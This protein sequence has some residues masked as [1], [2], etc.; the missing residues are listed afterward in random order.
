MVRA[1]QK[2]FVATEPSPP[3]ATAMAPSY[4]SSPSVTRR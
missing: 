3:W 2:P 4:A 1:D